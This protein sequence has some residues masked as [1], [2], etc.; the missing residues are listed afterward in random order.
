MN[1]IKRVVIT[2]GIGSMLEMYDFVIYGLIAPTLAILF[3]PP[4][5]KFTAIMSSF[6]V[7]AVGFLARPAG[8][9]FFGHFGDRLGRKSVLIF[10][11][12]TMA[13]ASFFIA[14][15]PTYQE[16]KIWAPVLLII[17]RI[18]QG[19]A[20]GGELAGAVTFVAEF[21]NVHHRGFTTSWIFFFV[22]MGVVLASLLSAI[23][24]GLLSHHAFVAW[25][26]RMLFFIGG[27]LAIVGIY[28][29]QKITE[30]P[31]FKEAEKKHLLIK[32]PLLDIFSD[33]KIL[34]RGLGISIIISVLVGMII[35][36][37]PSYLS[38]TLQMP[39]TTALSLNTINVLILSILIPVMGSISDKTG[40]KSILL[41][42][43]TGLLLFSYPLFILLNKKNDALI[44][45]GL[46]GFALFG[47]AMLGVFGALLAEL[48][49][50]RSRF[51]CIAFT[52]NISFALFAGTAP[53]V[54]LYLIHLTKNTLSPSFY[55]MVIALI[56]L[57]LILGSKETRKI[58][59]R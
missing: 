44:M 55:L 35:M 49:P 23:F 24:S 1:I 43:I 4:S 20:V 38:A 40:R 16:I 25:G 12:A 7:F 11:I 19:F 5:D 21:S 30:T 3:F 48:F 47:A 32:I 6:A 51:T 13:I 54:S 17:L 34:I 27:L 33:I 15:I 57:L 56:S 37:M 50:T 39:L 14:I 31:L 53:L 46:T 8:S 10:T 41:F 18:L 42:G 45:I 28:L 52:Y 26:W 36:Y 59:L 9:L 29:R 22:N 2:A 58:K